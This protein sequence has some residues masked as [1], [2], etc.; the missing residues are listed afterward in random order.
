M[1]WFWLFIF[2]VTYVGIDDKDN[3]KQERKY[4]KIMCAYSMVVIV[5]HC[6]CS[7]LTFIAG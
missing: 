3:S 7:L 5:G 4:A 2:I 1:S 6:L